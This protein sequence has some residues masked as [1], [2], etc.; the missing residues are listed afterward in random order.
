[1]NPPHMYFKTFMYF[2]FAHTDIRYVT[3]QIHFKLTFEQ[4]HQI[5]LYGKNKNVIRDAFSFYIQCYKKMFF[6]PPT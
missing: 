4:E 6:D 2:L 3:F 1:M 5:L